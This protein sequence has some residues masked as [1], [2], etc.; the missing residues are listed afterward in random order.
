MAEI[1]ILHGT[2][3][4]FPQAVLEA[5]NSYRRGCCRFLTVDALNL[6]D[7]QNSGW[8]TPVVLDL[9]SRRLPFLNESLYLVWQFSST[10]VLNEPRTLRLHNRA[11]V[12]QLA[13]L[14]GFKTSAAY[15][16]P[17]RETFPKLPHEG[18]V[19]LKYPVSWEKA[20]EECG[21]YPILQSLAFSGEQGGLITDLGTLW[22]RYNETGSGLQ[23]LVSPPR[24]ERIYRVYFVGEVVLVREMDL[25][26]RQLYP[27]SALPPSVTRPLIAAARKLRREIHLD[28]SSFDFGWD[29][30]EVEYID[31]NPDPTLEWWNLGEHD[32]SLLVDGAVNLLKNLLMPASLSAAK[33]TDHK[34]ASKKK[35]KP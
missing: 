35:G 29:G 33:V 7:Y 34:S 1:G 25:L 23:E 22:R 11:T 17:A 27:N 3:E 26:T 32:F 18:F 15:L 16:F 20:L 19:N 31:L 5:L 9:F 21:P 24:S 12:R 8:S 10:K 30:D 14:A 28:I 4:S 13:R 2:R 6:E